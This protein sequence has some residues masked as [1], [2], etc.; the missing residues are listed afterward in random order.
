MEEVL[1]VPIE[2][3]SADP[4]TSGKS[5]NADTRGDASKEP[6]ESPKLFSEGHLFVLTGPS[7]R[8]Y[9][10]FALELKGKH[11]FH[12]NY[13]CTCARIRLMLYVRTYLLDIVRVRVFSYFSTCARILMI[14]SHIFMQ[15]L[16]HPVSTLHLS[17]PFKI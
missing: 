14:H 13:Y 1:E 3:P 16:H 6:E 12:P 8:F 17:S 15:L 4:E 11:P 5:E 2:R 10:L 9:D 7:A